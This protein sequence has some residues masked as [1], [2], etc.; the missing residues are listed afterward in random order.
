MIRPAIKVENGTA[1]IPDAPGL[2]VEI[3]EDAVER[4]RVEEPPQ[5][6]SDGHLMVLRWPSGATSYYAREEMYK[7]DF[8]AG[9]LPP[10]VTGIH[11]EEVPNDGSME[12]RDLQARAA[13]AGVHVGGRPM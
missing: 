7:A 6:S 8:I 11:V 5:L 3:D 13:K 1:A 2:G 9:R 10:F 12:W 4:Y